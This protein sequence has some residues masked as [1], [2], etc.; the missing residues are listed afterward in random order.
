MARDLIEQRIPNQKNDATK[1][2]YSDS[3]GAVKLTV[4][5]KEFN[6][7]DHAEIFHGEWMREFD[8]ELEPFHELLHEFPVDFS[9]SYPYEEEPDLP[10]QYMSTR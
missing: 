5:K 7:A 8:R 4:G 2:Q 9:P 1:V 10:H 6:H 3:D